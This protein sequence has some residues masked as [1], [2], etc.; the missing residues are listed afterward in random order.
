[1]LDRMLARARGRQPNRQLLRR[2]FRRKVKADCID[3][4]WFLGLK[5]A[6]RKYEAFRD[7]YDCILTHSSTGLK[8]LVGPIQSI[9]FPDP[10]NRS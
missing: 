1:M 8:T 3:Q 9:S 4:N 6:N 10:L 7:S 5:D 2:S